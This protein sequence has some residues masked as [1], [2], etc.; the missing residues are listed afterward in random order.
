M[1]QL[2]YVNSYFFQLHLIL[3]ACVRKFDV[4][5][6]AQTFLGTKHP[7]SSSAVQNKRKR[8]QQ[9][10]NKAVLQS[11]DRVQKTE[12]EKIVCV[13]NSTGGRSERRVPR[14]VPAGAWGS[15]RG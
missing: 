9:T 1:N 6:T 3:H 12:R 15:H 10:G 8:P 7:L 11:S 2:D 14:P 5:G 13:A 4:T